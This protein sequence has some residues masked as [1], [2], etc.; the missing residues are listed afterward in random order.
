LIFPPLSLHELIDKG[1]CDTLTAK[2]IRPPLDIAFPI[3]PL[4]YTPHKTPFHAQTHA[5]LSQSST[6]STRRTKPTR[7]P[8]SLPIRWKRKWHPGHPSRRWE[9]HP[10]RRRPRT[11]RRRKWH[12]SHIRWWERQV[13]WWPGHVWG[14][15]WRAW[16][17]TVHAEGWRHAAASEGWE[18]G[19]WAAWESSWVWPEIG[20]LQHG[21]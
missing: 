6:T 2:N 3:I 16:W 8:W 12:S 5:Q 19:W 11:T 4:I 14:K 9:R 18:S 21:V 15:I 1:Y 7:A 13:W 10:L 17:R 20:G